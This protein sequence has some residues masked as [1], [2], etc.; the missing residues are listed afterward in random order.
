[1]AGHCKRLASVVYSCFQIHSLLPPI[2][3]ATTKPDSRSFHRV[4]VPLLFSFH[5]ASI[6]IL[7]SFHPAS[8]SILFRFHSASIPILLNFYSASTQLLTIF[9]QDSIQH[10]FSF[11]RAFF[12]LSFRFRSVPSLA[13]RF[14][15]A[16]IPFSFNFNELPFSINAEL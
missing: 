15:T 13:S 3:L 11:S 4:P 10:L 12:E 5:P 14:R 6:P 2:C 7:L 16:S 9:H 8:I 1:M